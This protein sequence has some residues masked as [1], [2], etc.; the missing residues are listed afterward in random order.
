VV[1]LRQWV[2]LVHA[3]A[4]VQCS[5]DRSISMERVTTGVFVFGKEG[6]LSFYSSR[7]GLY[8]GDLYYAGRSSAGGL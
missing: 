1:E 6:V 3:C 2:I 5:V 4:L 8:T 7:A